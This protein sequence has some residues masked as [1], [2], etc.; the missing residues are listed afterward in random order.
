INT[1]ALGTPADVERE[2]KQT[3]KNAAPGGG[4]MFSTSNGITY[5]CPSENVKAMIAAAKKYGK[6]PVQLNDT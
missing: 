5:Y 4:Y 3:I 2:V 6:Y 1:L